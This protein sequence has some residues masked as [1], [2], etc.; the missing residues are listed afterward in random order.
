MKFE[1]HQ[2]D[3]SR[4]L[5]RFDSSGSFCIKQKLCLRAQVYWSKCYLTKR[6]VSCRDDFGFSYSIIELFE[7]TRGLSHKSAKVNVKYC[8]NDTKPLP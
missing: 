3:L 6:V 7:R 4:Y 1:C 5:F 2:T 8:I